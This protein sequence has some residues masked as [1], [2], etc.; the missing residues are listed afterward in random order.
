MM[1][2]FLIHCDAYLMLSHVDAHIQAGV[3]LKFQWVHNGSIP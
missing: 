3:W 1:N 2:D